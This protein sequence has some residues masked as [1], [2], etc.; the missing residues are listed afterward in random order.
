MAG[1]FDTFTL[2]G[3][4]LACA[5]LGGGLFL[6]RILLQLLGADGVH[7]LSPEID[8]GE[9]DA[10]FQFL[11]LQGI[12]SFLMM[13]GLVGLAMDRSGGLPGAVS[14]LAATAA[15]FASVWIV[16]RIYIAMRGLQSSGN[17]DIESAVG[18]EGTIYLTVPAN[19]RGKIQL[20]VSGRLREYD[21]ISQAG[22]ELPTG[23]RVRV[24]AAVEGNV[25]SVVAL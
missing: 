13:F 3:L 9:T 23:R 22:V 18:A 15:G 4:F 14:V 16:G 7:D 6:V 12:A 2:G 11:S 19:G 1:I 25:L 21:A 10:S 8:A 20:V 5:A 24:A 17:V